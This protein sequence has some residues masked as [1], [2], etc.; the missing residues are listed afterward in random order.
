VEKCTLEQNEQ[1]GPVGLVRSKANVATVSV[2]DDLNAEPLLVGGEQP[3]TNL[4]NRGI[5]QDLTR[6]NF[7]LPH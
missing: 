2:S 4:Q 7:P 3:R 6:V 1:D 5:V